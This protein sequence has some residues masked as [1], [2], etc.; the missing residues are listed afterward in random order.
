MCRCVDICSSMCNSYNNTCNVAMVN[1]PQWPTSSKWRKNLLFFLLSPL[2]ILL[3]SSSSTLFVASYFVTYFHV[4]SLPNRKR[5]LFLTYFEKI[6]THARIYVTTYKHFTIA[7][8]FC[9]QTQIRYRFHAPA[10]SGITDCIAHHRPLKLNVNNILHYPVL[11]WT[12]FQTNLI[13]TFTRAQF[14]SR[15]FRSRTRRAS[16][17]PASDVATEGRRLESNPECTTNEKNIS[18]WNA[19]AHWELRYDWSIYFQVYEYTPIIIKSSLNVVQLNT[20]RNPW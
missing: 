11:T 5:S 18:H 12:R 15:F 4:F 2:K 20:K 14:Y 3:K 8:L 16:L 1:S 10:K 13:L 9:V 19:S 6:Q 17:P 7:I